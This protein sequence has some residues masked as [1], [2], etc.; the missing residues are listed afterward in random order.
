M[1]IYKSVYVQ[2]T[3]NGS[4]E[5]LESYACVKH[6]VNISSI[7]YSRIIKYREIAVLPS[8]CILTCYLWQARQAQAHGFFGGWIPAGD[9]AGDSWPPSWLCP[10][11]AALRAL[12]GAVAVQDGVSCSCIILFCLLLLIV[13]KVIPSVGLGFSGRINDLAQCN[14]QTPVL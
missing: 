13:F 9:R 5:F 10:V 12:P 11:C 8:Y 6:K 7:T 2:S 1:H 14:A 4:K 3:L